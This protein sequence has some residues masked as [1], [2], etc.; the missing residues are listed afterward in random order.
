[1]GQTVLMIGTR[2]GL[3]LASSEDR[4][5]WEVTGPDDLRSEVHAVAFDKGADR[6]GHPRMFMASKSWHWGPQILRS[7][8]LGKTWDRGPDGAIRFPEDTE[9]TLEAV[10]SI[11]PSTAEDGVVWAGTEPSALFR[12]EDGGET[13]SLV[14]PLWDHPHRPEW[15]AGFGGQAIHTLLPHPHDADQLAVAMSTGGVYLTAD[16]GE[17]WAPANVGIKA[18]F[19]PGDRTFPEF[20]QCV[21]KITRDAE[22]PDTLFAQNH[23]GVYRSDDAAGTWNDIAPGLPSEFGFPVVAHPHRSGTIYLFP[24]EGA[25]GRFPPG[26]AC[27]VWRSGDAGATWEELGNGLPDGNFFTG[28]MRDAMCVDDAD[29][30]GV[31]FGSRD[32]SVFASADEGDHWSSVAE[33]LPDVLCVRAATV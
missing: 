3:F 23:G 24:L 10:W 17:S 6:G 1:M 33:H 27:R 22:Q 13:F 30:A 14:R 31:Y 29:P 25:D 8:D 28:V 21:H 16:R 15:G 4:K 32:G 20:G 9:T 2:K 11:A 18:E 7:D 12:S 26:G 5:S 19:F